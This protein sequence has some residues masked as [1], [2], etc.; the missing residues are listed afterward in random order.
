MLKEV[1]CG[2]V[3]IAASVTDIRKRQF[4]IYLQAL[5]CLMILIDFKVVNLLGGLWSVPFF[6]ANIR[7]K[8]MG[9]GDV[10][11]VLLLGMAS[12]F[13]KSFWLTV[14]ALSLFVSVSYILKRRKGGGEMLL[15]FLPYLTIAYL[16]V[17]ILEVLM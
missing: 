7:N 13:I 1:L 10:K 5:L 12:G 9:G 11:A 6:I 17:E 14:I 16:T 8:D 4:P 2:F 3:L 15:P